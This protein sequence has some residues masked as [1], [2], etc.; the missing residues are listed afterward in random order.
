MADSFIDPVNPSGVNVEGGA[1]TG[2][3][4]GADEAMIIGGGNVSWLSVS[5]QS[6]SMK[7]GG[8]Y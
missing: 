7:R 6:S 8:K 5:V 3:G 1:V 2:T 4:G